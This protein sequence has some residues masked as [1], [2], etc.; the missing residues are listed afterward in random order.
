MGEE[1]TPEAGGPG[2]PLRAGRAED[3]MS[4][5]AQLPV[6]T[7][8]FDGPDLVIAGLNDMADQAIGRPDALGRPFREVAPEVMFQ[9]ILEPLGRVYATGEPMV[10][11]ELRVQY[12]PPDGAGTE[13]VANVTATPWHHPDGSIRGVIACGQDVTE[14]VRSRQAAEARRA[15]AQQRY[16]HAR[17]VVTT[18]QE[19]LLP[20]DVPVLPRLQVAARYLLAE[21]DSAVG[22]DWFDALTLP[23]GRVAL[24]VGDVVGHGVKAST[25]MGRL[26]TVLA[27]RLRSGAGLDGSMAALDA[28]ASGT[29]GARA[30]TVNVAV[31]EPATGQMS[32]VTAGHPPPLVVSAD[33]SCRRLPTTGGGPLGTGS[34]HPA[35]GERLDDGEMIVLYSDGV[36]ERPG[37]TPAQGAAELAETVTDTALNRGLPHRAPL[38]QVERVC[39]QT[40]ELLTRLTGHTDDITLLAAQRTAPVHDLELTMPATADSV[41]GIQYEL[42]QWLLG[43]GARQ[44][45]ESALQHAVVELVTNAVEHAY[46]DDDADRQQPDV[47]VRASLRDDGRVRVQVADRGRWREADR[48]EPYRGNGLNMAGFFADDLSVAKGEHGGGTTV[49]LHRRLRRPVSVDQATTGRAR[50]AQTGRLDIEEDLDAPCRLTVAG[51]ADVTTVDRLEI[52]LRQ[53]TRNGTRSV[54]LDLSGIDHLASAGVQVLHALHALCARQGSS[55]TLYAPE[56]STAQSVLDLVAL[57]HTTQA[58][59]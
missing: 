33:G 24:I 54:T 19:A 48:T 53:A 34:A 50:R 10:A 43:L 14:M 15:E 46:R 5:F 56:G 3:V 59:A 45:D 22:G 58:P 38:V 26:R 8:V 17:D 21:E 41:R 44:T 55:L 49:T 16:E 40:L 35:R 11:P 42:G 23:D 32:Y 2:G 12:L 18:L 6:F 47:T 1:E 51:V 52:A 9:R 37:V 31:L 29:E 25:V 30:A 28:F 39:S 57:P 4:A 36:I 7:V 27:E 13:V 20:G